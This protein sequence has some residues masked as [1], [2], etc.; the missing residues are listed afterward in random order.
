MEIYYVS[1]QSLKREE[2]IRKINSNYQPNTSLES[3]L[4]KVGRVRKLKGFVVAIFL[5]TLLIQVIRYRPNRSIV[6]R[7]V[8]L[9][10]LSLS[11]YPIYLSIYSTIG[12]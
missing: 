3:V 2:M 10:Y 9:I 8:L 6:D 7:I 5:I 12:M 4:Q 11:I 1:I